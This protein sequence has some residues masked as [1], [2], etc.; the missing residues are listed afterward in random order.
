MTAG[1]RRVFVVDDEEPIRRALRLLLQ[2]EGISVRTFASAG[3]ALAALDTERPDCVLTDYHMPGMNGI[4]LIRD[5][6][7]RYP[8]LPLVMMTGTDDPGRIDIAERVHL[9]QK[10]FDVAALARLLATLADEAGT[11]SGAA[12]S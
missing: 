6:R 3:E 7:R 11:A 5:V 1:P 10:P 4:E 9:L 8:S 12:P 2:A